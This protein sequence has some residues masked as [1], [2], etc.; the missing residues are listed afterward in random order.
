MKKVGL[1]VVAAL[2]MVWTFSM[3]A[4]AAAVDYD[5]ESNEYSIVL[6]SMT[7]EE[8]DELCRVL[9]LECRGE[10]FEGKV[11]CV[12]VIF[13]RILS[14]NWPDT[15]HEV[16]SQAGQFA[17]WRHKDTAYDVD[18]D[19][20]AVTQAEICRAI[21]YAYQNGRTVLPSEKYVY[22]DTKGINGSRHIKVGHQYF[23]AE[24]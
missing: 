21:M 8:V 5:R 24:R 17:T 9:F 11:A 22:F 6:E 14:D 7:D 15:A 20:I 3:A 13:N 23:G 2:V 12:E 4:M 1:V 18:E 10:P 16:L 19:D